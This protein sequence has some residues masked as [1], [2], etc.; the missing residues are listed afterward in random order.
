MKKLFGT[1]GIRG[2]AGQS[3]LDAPTIY[4]IGLALAHHLGS[5]P[6]VLLGMDTRESGNWIAATLTAGLTAGGAT[7]ESPGVIATPAIAFLTPTP[8]FSAGI[9]ISASHNPWQDNGIKV[10]G[11]DGYKLADAVELA[12]EDEIFKHLETV[13]APALGELSAP[14]V[15]DADRAEY[16]RFLLA[17]VPN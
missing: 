10:F 11:P 1:D 13:Q 2:I 3:P 5:S 6:K 12:I 4:A 8:G 9:V 16:V 17:A 7:R 15:N 14:A